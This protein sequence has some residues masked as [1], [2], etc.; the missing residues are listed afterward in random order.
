MAV[1]WTGTGRTGSLE[2]MTRVL[3]VLSTAAAL[4]GCGTAGI[5]LSIPVGGFG[6]VSVGVDSS[7]RVGGGVGVGRGGVSVGVGG[8]AQLPSSA[9]AAASAVR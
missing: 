9:D 6:G 5:S 1:R 7:G 2:R 8:T 4:A 3:L